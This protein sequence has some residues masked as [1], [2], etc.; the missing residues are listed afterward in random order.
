MKN[1]APRPGHECCALFLHEPHRLGNARARGA[2]A[3]D[4]VDVVGKAE[5][6]AAYHAADRGGNNGPLATMLLQIWLFGLYLSSMESFF[7]D[8]ADPLWFTFLLSVFGLHYL[9]RFRVSD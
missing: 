7:L 9:A 1:A 8:R 2:V 6:D 3:V 5:R 4:L